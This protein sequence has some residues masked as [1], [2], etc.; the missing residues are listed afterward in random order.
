MSKVMGISVKF[1]DDH[2]I[3]MVTSRDYS[4]KFRKFLFLAKFCINFWEKSPN[5]EEI[6]SRTKK[7][8]VQSKYLSGPPS[9][10]S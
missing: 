8:Q 2:S 1:Y 3:N 5:V 6:D 4:C 10:Y 7:L 9:A